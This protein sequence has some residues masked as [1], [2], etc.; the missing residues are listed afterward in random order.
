MKC[1][2]P[3]VTTARVAVDNPPV[4]SWRPASA[5]ASMSQ[6]CVR[7]ARFDPFLTEM[8]CAGGHR[9]RRRRTYV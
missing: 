9:L 5:C 3:R 8:T 2:A 6:G 7:G 4:L 1:Q